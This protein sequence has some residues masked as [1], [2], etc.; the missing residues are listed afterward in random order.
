[1]NRKS[2]C[3]FLSAMMLT[4]LLISCN[5]DNGH[6]SLSPAELSG[7]YSNKLSVPANG[8]SLIL[9]YNGNTFIGKDVAFKTDDGKTAHIILKY[10]L[11]HDAETALADIPLT[12]ANGGYSFSGNATATTGTTFRYQG[13]IQAK[14]LF[15]EL[16]DITIPENRLTANG[17]WHVAHENASYYNVD[18][19]SMQTMTGMLYNLVGGKLVSNLISSVLNDLTFRAD[20]N[21]IARYA[22]LPDS[23][24]IG[25]L[26][27][28]YVKHPANDWA[29]SPSNLATY[30]VEGN[31]S[32]YVIPQVDMI[33]R[34]V[35]VNKQ[36]KVGSGDSS[37]ENAL[38]AAYRKINAWSTTGIKMTIRES[39][40]PAKGDLILLLDKPEIQ[41]LFALL[42]IVK[43]FLPEET[44]NTPVTDL[45]GDLIPPQF[46]SIAGILLQGK[47]LG[48]ILD[49]LSRELNAIPIEIGIYLY[50]DKPV[51]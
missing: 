39:E 28:N 12:T 46:A 33:I 4:I 7:I 25:N 38:L 44:L 21:I 35:M 48:A 31:A 36:T 41:E 40:A 3:R 24:R 5:D 20:G 27:G 29:A 2:I 11:P 30:H 13:S 14:R 9:S 16:S 23:V 18:N 51:N 10:V 8:D 37:M 49:Q 17:T 6:D 15:L 32:L 47:T 43:V 45:I 1:M 26:I 22:P 50:K 42:D 34:Q 19:G